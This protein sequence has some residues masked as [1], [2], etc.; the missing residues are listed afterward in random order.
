MPNPALCLDDEPRLARGT[1]QLVV[2]GVDVGNVAIIDIAGEGDNFTIFQ[3]AVL[4][5]SDVN[6]YQLSFQRQIVIEATL[7]GFT[8]ENLELLLKETAVSVSGGDRMNLTTI[9]EDTLHEVNFYHDLRS[10]EGVCAQIHVYLRRAFI[11]RPWTLPLRRDA[12]SEYVLRFI[13]LADVTHPTSQFGYLELIC[14]S[15]VS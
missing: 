5:P 12:F 9:S 15:E 1:G 4:E 6:P 11:E 14:P 3:P 7:D 13:A 8:L 10:C 2:D